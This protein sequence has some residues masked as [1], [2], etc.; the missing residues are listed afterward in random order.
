M[1]KANPETHQACRSLLQKT[2]R[3]GDVA[4]TQ[5]VAHHLHEIGD[6]SWLKMRTAVITFE[7]CWP[8]GTE[9]YATKD[10]ESITCALVRTARMVKRKD[11]TGLGSLAYALSTG[12]GSVLSGD[13]ED[14][15]IQHVSHAIKMPD[16]FWLWATKNCANDNQRILI[17]SA[18]KA[19]RRGGWPWDRAF[20]QAAAYLAITEGIP[21]I[22]PVPEVKQDFPFW[23]ALDKHTP[24]GKEALS[25]AARIAGFPVRQVTWVSFYFESALSNDS[26]DSCW[27]NREIQ[28][29][30]SRIGL[31]LGKAELI[32]A[33]TRP[34]VM[35]ILR[36]E[37]N[38]LKEH[39]GS[40]A[41]DENVSGKA[42]ASQKHLGDRISHQSSLW[43]TERVQESVDNAVLEPF[44]F[45]KIEHLQRHGSSVQ[46]R[47][48]GF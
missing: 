21:D 13:P 8:L 19:Y 48:P 30:L 24:K 43:E 10:I 18:Q 39:L 12:D 20:M 9:I 31:D 22:Y 11:A 6:T 33:K 45:E 5:I 47:L 23:V 35:N 41:L 16:Q 36:E 27:W 32:W 2:V 28:W 4:L 42:A 1:K 38:A 40:E 44:V 3:R 29:R 46:S 26:T 7:E 17:E 15:C 25:E 14:Q 37:A 34:I